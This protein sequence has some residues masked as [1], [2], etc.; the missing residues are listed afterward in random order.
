MN[1][2]TGQAVRRGDDDEV[3]LS[4]C[5]AITQTVQP[6]AVERGTAIAVITV[7][8]PVVNLSALLS[9]MRLQPSKLLVDGL[10]LCLAQG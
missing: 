6:G 5:G 3:D 7:D 10:S 4:Q 1:I 2:L 9:D 8:V